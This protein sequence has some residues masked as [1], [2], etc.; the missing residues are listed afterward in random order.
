MRTFL[1]GVP[2]VLCS[3]LAADHGAPAGG[4]GTPAPAAP[5]PPEPT[6]N[7]LE[8]KFASAWTAAKDYFRQLSGLQKERD[9]FQAQ[10]IGAT[11]RAEKA[12]GELK[13]A[14][15]TIAAH[16]KTIGE[17]DAKINEVSAN[18]EKSNTAISALENF[19]KGH[20]LD[21]S[22]VDRTKAVRE[23]AGS[24]PGD[25]NADPIRAEYTRL[26]SE[27]NAGR[28]APGSTFK[29]YK[30]NKKHLDSAE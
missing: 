18:L 20:N 19:C 11:Q 15:D 28:V 26:R 23:V 8:E 2:F 25:D 30:K 14:N 21:L 22:G 12:E 27:E 10:A 5:E 17:K 4:G 29:F 3:L 6:G 9:D 16:V 1:S 13:S 7:T 24:G